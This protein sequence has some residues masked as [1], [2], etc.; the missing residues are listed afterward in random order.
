MKKIIIAILFLLSIIIVFAQNDFEEWEKS[1]N[2][3]MQTFKEKNDE[4]F[5]NFL[6]ENWQAYKAF[7]GIVPD[8]KPKPKKMPVAKVPQEK[9]PDN[10]PVV[11]I[12]PI[13]PQEPKVEEKDK[14]NLKVEPEKLPMENVSEEKKSEN[15]TAENMSPI[16]PQE[17]IVEGKAVEK[18]MLEPIVVEPIKVINF[19]F[20]G[21]NCSV[22]YK[23]EI[24]LPSTIDNKDIADFFEEMSKSKYQK[25]LKQLQEYKLQMKLNDYAYVMLL[26]RA[27]E[28]VFDDKRKATLFTWFILLKSGYSVKVAYDKNIVYLLL[29]SEQILYLTSYLKIDNKNYYFMTKNDLSKDVYTYKASYPNADKSINMLFENEVNIT[30]ENE[31]KVLTFSY[32][33]KEYNVFSSYNKSAI[34]LYADYPQTNMD[35]YYETPLSLS[36]KEKLLNSLGKIIDG[37]S[38]TEAINILLAFVQKGFKYKTDDEQFGKEK[39]FFPEEIFYY[40]YSDCEDRSILFAYLVRNLLHLEVLGLEY[41][42]HMATAVKFSTFLQG[43]DNL[44]YEGKNYIICDPTY[45]NAQLGMCMPQFKNVKA[46]VVVKNL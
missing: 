24:D 30:E 12:A 31:K 4:T 35:I 17:P 25:A 19:Q 7:K 27:S 10:S 6:E 3:E 42:G 34:A 28:K 29:P 16:L 15:S 40:P 43:K 18:P 11:E 36:A 2:K 23:A 33:G 46:K 45:L 21:K 14:K 13:L 8:K 26:Q 20:Y 22:N 41:P 9:E 1:Q 37:K 39:T 5:K 32:F 38:E 44:I